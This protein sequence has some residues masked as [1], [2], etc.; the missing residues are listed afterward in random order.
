MVVYCLEWCVLRFVRS[1]HMLCL[2]N[3]SQNSGEKEKRRSKETP[4][5]WFSFSFETRQIWSCL[6]A[7]VYRRS[8]LSYI[9]L[10]FFFVVKEWTLAWQNTSTRLLRVL[11]DPKVNNNKIKPYSENVIFF[12]NIYKQCFR[13]SDVLLN[14]NLLVRR[15]VRIKAMIQYI[16]ETT[17]TFW[18]CLSLSETIQ[19]LQTAVFLFFTVLEERPKPTILKMMELGYTQLVMC[20]W[21]NHSSLPPNRGH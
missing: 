18:I 21:P 10:F 12:L 5:T 19:V 4:G 6:F 8:Q 13:V 9:V 3:L 1:D 7:F 11:F 2:N 20:L 17:F 14:Q 15:C 16:S